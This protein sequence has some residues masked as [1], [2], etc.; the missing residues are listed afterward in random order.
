MPVY[1]DATAPTVQRTETPDESG[2]SEETAE[3]SESEES[4]EGAEKPDLNVLARQVFP[5]IK[6]MLAVEQERRG[7]R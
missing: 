6:R 4:G 1:L 3:G 7:I 5:I 2:G